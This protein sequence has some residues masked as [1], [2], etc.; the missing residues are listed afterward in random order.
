MTH[1]RAVWFVCSMSKQTEMPASSPSAR[2]SHRP[3]RLR[4]ALTL[5]SAALL[6]TCAGD[7]GGG[8]AKSRTISSVAISPSPVSIRV[9]A[10]QALT[11]IGT[12][13]DASTAPVST[14]LVFTSSDSTKAS[15]SAAGVITGVSPGNATVTAT[16]GGRSA[17]VG[18][19]VTPATTTTL[20]SIALPNGPIGLAV[21]QTHQLVVTGTYSDGSTGVVGTGLVFQSASPAV[22]EVDATGLITARSAGTAV[23]TTSVGALSST[24]TVHCTAPSLA[25]VA[26]TPDPVL[27]KVGDT[28]QLELTGSDTAGGITDLSTS[29]TWT[30]AN[31]SV[32][33]VSPSGLVTA[34]TVGSTTIMGTATVAGVTKSGT[35]T[36][37]VTA[38]SAYDPGAGWNLAWSDE[39]DGAAVDGASWTFDL[40][41][42][43]WGNSESQYYRAENAVVAG[44]ALTITAK[45]ESFGDAP[46]T[47]ARMQTSRK[48][49]FTYGKFS[50]RAKL[51][52]GQGLW[53]AFWL[54]GTNSA[55]F[56]LY[57]GDVV[58]PGCGEADVMEMIGGLADGSGDFTTHGTLHYLN[59]AGHNPAP[60][61]T[62]RNPKKLSED[63]HVYELVWTPHSFTWKFDGVAFGTKLIGADMEEFSKPMF[64][65]L[66]LAVGGA[67]G[68][69]ADGTTV[70]PQS[71]V[72]D[73]VRVYQNAST[74][75]GD[76]A[77]GLTTIWHLSNT[78]STGVTPLAEALDVNKGTASGFQLV[79]VLG[80]PAAWYG[81]PQTGSYE[82]GAWSVGLFTSS[83]A[84]SAGAAVVR[85][86]LFKTAAD[87]SA[88]LSLGSSQVDVS[89]TGSGN[90]ASWII[91][92]GVPAVQLTNERIKLVVTRV[93]GAE[94]TLI[95]NGNDF[96]SLLET[97]WSAARP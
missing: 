47:S 37:T 61:F 2:T 52:Y 50:I 24:V 75:P 87:G 96:D 23:L 35:T 28:A 68:G 97:P 32:I 1:S 90:H 5:L 13:S 78:P 71:Y 8:D 39:F 4:D 77:P 18:I 57:G 44:G 34:L 82:E 31:A 36:I 85:V 11:V 66:N 43:G 89:T 22:A 83:S 70:F 53:P 88:A 6:A 73:W 62:L 93:S 15:V 46:Y 49:T 95:Y 29:A 55:S 76:D 42:G 72:V 19:I 60:S 30:S 27:L 91:L 67:W 58:W 20:V 81:P 38:T 9:G 74:T 80:S 54:L 12:F 45:A 51:P 65:L 16:A 86:E 59:A 48:R 10:S 56:D 3:G 33:S 92:T 41:S 64:I 69:W 63:F 14:G 40:G 7:G 17:S 84:S 25:S 21:N 79:K 94:V 26:V